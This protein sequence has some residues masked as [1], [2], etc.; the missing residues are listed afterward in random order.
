VFDAARFR[1][2]YPFEGRF[3][4]CR[5]GHRMH[6]LDEGAGDPVVMLHGNPTWSFYYRDLA[7]GVR[8]GARVI[9]PDHIGCGLSDKP[10]AGRYGYRL[11]DRVD[12][13]DALLS[14]IGADSGVTLVLHDW[15]GMIGMAW[16]VRHPD[17]VR[18]LV[19]LNTAA[20]RLPAGKRLPWSLRL[21]RDTSLGALLVRGAN[22]FSAAATWVCTAER[23]LA[24]DVRAAYRAPY[25]TWAHRIATLRFV[26]DIPLAAGD[27][28]WELVSHVDG[29]L[30]RFSDLP[31]LI[32]WGERDFVFDARFLAEW[33]RRFPAAEVHTFP[34]AGHWVL[35][36]AGD[37]IVP[38]VRAFL[39]REQASEA[40]RI[41]PAVDGSPASAGDEG[42]SSGLPAPR[43]ARS[44][45][46]P[47]TSRSA[48]T[49]GW[50]PPAA[51]LPARERSE[52]LPTP[53]AESAPTA[54]PPA[55]GLPVPLDVPTANIASRLAAAARRHPDKIAVIDGERRLSFAGLDAECDCL[56]R[57]LAA[58]GIGRG[59]RTV[60]M[61]RPGLEFFALAFALFR[62]G[63]VPVMVDPGMGRRHLGGCLAEA[64]PEAFIGIPLAHAARVL[65]GWG[66]RTVRTTVTVG[67]RWF[68]G[69]FTL[70]QVRARGTD[71]AT[72]DT[73]PEGGAKRTAGPPGPLPEG[74]RRPPSGPPGPLPEGGRRPPSDPPGPLPEGG[75]RPPSGPPGPLPAPPADDVAAILFTSGST[76][77]PKGAVYTHRIFAAQVDMLASHFGIDSSDVDLPTFPLFALFD[78]AL[79]A[80]A[81]IPRMDFTR[82]ADVDPEEILSAIRAHSV[83]QMF[84]SPALLDRVG[85]HGAARG[86]RLPSLRRVISAGA[87]VSPIVLERFASL[88]DGAAEIHTPYGATEALPVASIGSR[89]VLDATRA[90]WAAGRG[91]CV[92]RPLPGIDVAIV[93]ITDDPIPQWS[94][95]LRR[96]AGEIGEIAVR[97]PVVT[98]AYH[99]RA[100][101]TLAA[102]IASA[103]GIWHRMGDVGYVDGHGRLWFCGRKSHRVTATGGTLYTVPC[104]AVF[105]Q[106][107]RVK[108]TA[109]VGL[110][111][112]GRQ[113]PVLCVEL[114]G[115]APPP[116]A[117]ADAL[118]REILALG[119]A[120]EHTRGIRDLLFHPSFP[121]DVRHNAKIFREEL[122]T[123]AGCRLGDRSAT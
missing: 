7:K 43:G 102:K 76:G 44:G 34:E 21:A 65:L 101:A 18:R 17:R 41:A 75:R 26:Q 62:T 32:L 47:Q 94:E 49:G 121:V 110:G 73:E 113:R 81:V 33:R 111:P 54:G 105:N 60:L 40:S 27:P 117:P 25:D 87:P 13:L 23:T 89:E 79:G 38:I 80:T 86:A 98:P 55:A 104:E 20:F 6:Y 10:D 58:C 4:T 106:H 99:A 92:G 37:R 14:A 31:V 119:Q 16:A 68:W 67:R 71:P 115:G 35:E 85:T 3:F 52:R 19:V 15:G 74:G 28:S 36:D 100:A 97:G 123:W 46:R 63:A 2:L 91:A 82:P 72:T 122:A 112:P 108:R 107:P 95:D 39:A 114:A 30:A 8:D 78:A 11:A 88:L 51:G 84:G 50:G 116:G 96:P 69:G 118:A 1:H 59:V 103:R 56:A 77:P 109:L 61:V 66:R 93:P 64:E 90:A 53:V 12:D 29:D 22:A 45:L 70:A 5:G 24:P 120:H 57:G 48:L 42:S 83:T 9:V